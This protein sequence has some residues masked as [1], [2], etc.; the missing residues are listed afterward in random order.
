VIARFKP[1]QWDALLGVLQAAMVD[2]AA[3]DVETDAGKAW[4]ALKQYLESRPLAKKIPGK[5]DPYFWE[6]FMSGGPFVM[7]GLIWFPAKWLYAHAYPR[8]AANRITA[9]EFYRYLKKMG[10]E[11]CDSSIPW[12]PELVEIVKG[13]KSYEEIRKTFTHGTYQE[14]MSLGEIIGCYKE[15]YPLRGYWVVS[16]SKFA[17]FL[18]DT[19]VDHD[20]YRAEIK[21]SLLKKLEEGDADDM[22]ELSESIG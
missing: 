7:D 14:V 19:P 2:E 20:D 11:K 10:A 3:S 16:T 18:R 9:G 4:Y 15:R 8:D 22:G 13:N 1:D 17:E 6:V 12:D 21:K 5:F